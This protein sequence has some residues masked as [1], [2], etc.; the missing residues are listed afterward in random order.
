M[1]NYD[2]TS[3]AIIAIFLRQKCYID[4]KE[5]TSVVLSTHFAGSHYILCSF[6]QSLFLWQSVISCR[7][8]VHAAISHRFLCTCRSQSPFSLHMPQSVTVFFAHAVVSHRFLCTCRSQSPFQSPY[9]LHMQCCS[10]IV[11]YLHIR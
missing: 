7:F 6:A 2:Y 11:T 3:M 10:K 1:E 4:T 8:F 9:S 5:L